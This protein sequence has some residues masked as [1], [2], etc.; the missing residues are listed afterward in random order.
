[1]H[2][3]TYIIS[4]TFPLSLRLPEFNV[5]NGANSIFLILLPFA[6]CAVNASICFNADLT[7][8]VRDAVRN[9]LILFDFLPN[10][11][12]FR[13]FSTVASASVAHLAPNNLD[14]IRALITNER[15]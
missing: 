8:H 15:E 1:M 6:E 10:F 4:R 12:F 11:F 13:K 7:D 5:Q 2:C 9:N 3:C 14:L